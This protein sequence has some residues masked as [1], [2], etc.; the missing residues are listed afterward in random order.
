[1][2]LVIWILLSLFPPDTTAKASAAIVPNGAS[3]MIDPNGLS[4]AIDPDGR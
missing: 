4:S 3:A 2:D 1:M